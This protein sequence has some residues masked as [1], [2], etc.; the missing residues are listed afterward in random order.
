MVKPAVRTQKWDII[1]FFMIFLV[2]LGHAS[3]FFRADSPGIRSLYLFI[4]T[5]HMP[6]FIF[7]SGLFSKKTVN[8]KQYSKLFGYVIIYFALKLLP[9][10]YWFADSETMKMSLLNETGLR[11]FMLALVAF[12]LL[13][14][15][16][17][18]VSP[19]FV[20]IVA[21]LFSC[22]A[23]YD[24]NV[25]DFLS[26]SRILVFYPFFYLG[27]CMDRNKVEKLCDNKILKV[28]AL[29]VVA[30]FVCVII[31]KVDDVYFYRMLVTGRRAY[32][33]FED[34]QKWGFVTRLVYY[35]VA[36]VVS[37]AVIVLVPKKTPFGICAKLGQR[38][39]A[40]YS[41]H[42]IAIFYIFEKYKFRDFVIENFGTKGVW[43]IIPI[44]IAITLFFSINIFQKA[45]LFI[46]NVPKRK[47]C[48][49]KDDLPTKA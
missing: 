34:M 44:A 24:E 48:N 1:K 9:F 27:Y 20:L 26:L 39:L 7:V 5:I 31:V 38:T 19:V 15:L 13:T 32:H 12:N 21:V 10:I 45:L 47:I 23:G 37:F 25:N 14:I 6:V 49:K 2:V 30:I 17:R 46:M 18:N 42:Y 8:E 3:E 16:V 28:A 4:Y 33:S 41:F 22:F 43:I 11:W 40:V 36:S 29:A 35:V